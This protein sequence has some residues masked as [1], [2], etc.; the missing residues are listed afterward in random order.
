MVLDDSIAC[1]I[2]STILLCI[3]HMKS[4]FC[5]NIWRIGLLHENSQNRLQSPSPIF[6]VKKTL[7]SKSALLQTVVQWL[8]L[9][10]QSYGRKLTLV[11]PSERTPC[12]LVFF[13]ESPMC[14][15]IQFSNC[16][17]RWAETEMIQKKNRLVVMY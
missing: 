15:I 9:L 5:I 3:V 16:K 17:K 8:L 4:W 13:G 1:L 10:L 6:F 11:F 7:L 14:S 2:R 12:R